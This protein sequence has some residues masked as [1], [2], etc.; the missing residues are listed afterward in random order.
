MMHGKKTFNLS[1]DEL[2]F[3]IEDHI[4]DCLAQIN[5][6]QPDPK[7]WLESANTAVGIWY[8]LTCIGAGIPEE[9]KETD[10]LRLMGIIQNGL[11]RIRPDLNI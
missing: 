2:T 11:K 5:E 8:S 9:T 7:L 6:Q 10:H 1:Y 4:L 3:A